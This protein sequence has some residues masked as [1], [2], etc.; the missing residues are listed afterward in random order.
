MKNLLFVIM[1]LSLAVACAKKNEKTSGANIHR[2]MTPAEVEAK[3]LNLVGYT[4]QNVALQNALTGLTVEQVGNEVKITYIIRRSTPSCNRETKTVTNLNLAAQ[5]EG[6]PVSGNNVQLQCL[7]NFC[8]NA[9]VKI[10]E[11]EFGGGT[12][13][14]ILAQQGTVWVPSV[15]ANTSVFHNPLDVRSGEAACWQGA[16]NTTNQPVNPTNY[17]DTGHLPYDWSSTWGW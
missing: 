8:R 15:S 16:S 4:P 14:V 5:R 9:L 17:L 6:F 7:S 10:T 3:A 1:C 12:V 13:N 11:F 2:Q